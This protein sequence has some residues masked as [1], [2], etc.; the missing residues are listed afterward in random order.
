MDKLMKRGEFVCLEGS[1]IKL[2][3]VSVELKWSA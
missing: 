3:A 2:I 1:Y